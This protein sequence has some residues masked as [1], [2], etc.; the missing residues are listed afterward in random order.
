MLLVRNFLMFQRIFSKDIPHLIH[1]FSFFILAD[2]AVVKN[3]AANT[4]AGI[5]FTQHYN[6]IAIL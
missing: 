6:I 4:G 5:T 1:L 3:K 2:L